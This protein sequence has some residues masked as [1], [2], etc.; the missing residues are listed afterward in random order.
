[1]LFFRNVIASI[2]SFGAIVCSQE[3]IVRNA[4]S[5]PASLPK[6]PQIAVSELTPRGISDGDAGVFSDRLRA[7]LMAN[8]KF[9]VMERGMMDQ[10]LKEQ[11]FQ[12]SGACDQSQCAVEI[13]KLLSVDRMVVGAVG[14]IGNLY[15][16]SVRVLDVKTGEVLQ[17]INQDFEGRIEAFVVQGINAVVEQIE[18]GGQ[19]D[20]RPRKVMVERGKIPEWDEYLNSVHV[21][22]TFPYNVLMNNWTSKT[23]NVGFSHM[24]RMDQIPVGIDIGFDAGRTLIARMRDDYDATTLRLLIAGVVGYGRV[25]VYTGGGCAVPLNVGDSASGIKWRYWQAELGGDVR[26]LSWLSFGIVGH[27]ALTPY[28]GDKVNL[29]PNDVETRVGVHF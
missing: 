16:L 1:M 10:L 15:T 17:S 13:G 14:K 11:A 22:M 25:S 5:A 19:G 2:F 12:S 3:V 24:F 9:R 21:S 4:D 27:R 23:L 7:G 8:G 29:W 18:L 28:K 6:I 20:L 26:A